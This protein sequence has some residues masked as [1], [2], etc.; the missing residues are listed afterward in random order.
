MTAHPCPEARPLQRAGL[1]AASSGRC[2]PKATRKIDA[3]HPTR[4]R[5][6]SGV[7]DSTRDRRGWLSPLAH[8]VRR[9]RSRCVSARAREVR[10]G[11]WGAVSGRFAGSRCAAGS[12]A[13][14]RGRAAHPITASA[15]AFVAT[16]VTL[17]SAARGGREISPAREPCQRL[18]LCAPRVSPSLPAAHHQYPSLRTCGE[19]TPQ[20]SSSATTSRTMSK[21]PHT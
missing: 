15:S 4:I 17:G 1:S 10:C 19:V 3:P 6:S 7:V 9:P 5:P 13:R 18:V 11:G 14:R 16:A 12:K 21:R 2:H 20:V 8:R